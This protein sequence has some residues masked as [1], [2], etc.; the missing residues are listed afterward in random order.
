MAEDMSANL[1]NRAVDRLHALLSD[2]DSVT[3]SLQRDN[4][5]MSQVRTLF[6]AVID[7]HPSTKEYLQADAAIVLHPNFKTA[8]AKIQD[9]R[10]NKL[11]VQQKRAVEFFETKYGC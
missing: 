6:D 1:M 7:E 5:T 2:L 11:T 8:I 9:G 3:K 4:I 10:A